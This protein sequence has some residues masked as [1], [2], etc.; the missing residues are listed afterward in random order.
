MPFKKLNIVTSTFPPRF[1]GVGDHTARLASELAGRLE[2][3]KVLTGFGEVSS[4]QGVCVGQFFSSESPRSIMSL[5]EAIRVDK[6]DWVVIQY[7]PFSY[8]ARYGFNPYLPLMVNRLKR[9]CPQVRLAVIVH[10]SFVSTHNWKSGVLA[11]ELKAQLWALCRAADAIFTATEPWVARLAAWFPR[12]TIKHLP[13]GSNIPHVQA[14]REEVRASLG[15]GGE[16]SVL[17]LFGRVQKTRSMEHVRSA[18]RRSQEAGLDVAVLY[19]GFDSVAARA[20][21]EGVHLI[22]D[23]PLSP[24][25]IS[26]RLA[27]VDVYMVPIDEGVS[28]RRT[29]LMTG[30]QH[31]LATVATSGP[32]TDAL[33][34]RENGRALMLAEVSAPE[35]F[36]EVVLDLLVNTERRALL[37]EGACELFSR[38]FNWQKIGSTFLT[39]LDTCMSEEPSHGKARS[40]ASRAG[41]PGG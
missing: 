17:G 39:T 2:E 11:L 13:V 6:P 33:L 34:A 14:R 23:G 19:M 35:K 9:R 5:V 22:A 12:K 37:S 30:L 40:L 27:A 7:D 41:I 21:L 36:A 4:P 28:T 15:I 32:A 1:C 38:E 31:G 25:E 16:T 3:V 18:V 10:E 8:G 29:T 24:D 20:Q 26:R